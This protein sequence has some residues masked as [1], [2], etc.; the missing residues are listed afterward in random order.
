ML[1]EIVDHRT[2]GT[3]LKQ[4][5]AFI[6]SRNGGRRR[7]ETTKGWEVLL[8]CKNGSTSWETLKDIKECYP[9]QVSKYAVR[10]RISDVPD[11]ARWLPHVIKKK[12]QII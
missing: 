4:H 11:F 5:D 3:E 7:H 8:Q 9:L 1:D 2:D 10:K 12:K 6:T